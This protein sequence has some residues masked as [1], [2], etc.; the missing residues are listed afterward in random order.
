MTSIVNKRILDVDTVDI[1]GILSDLQ[2]IEDEI[3]DSLRKGERKYLLRMNCKQREAYKN[4]ESMGQVLSVLVWDTI[5]PEQEILLPD[6]LDIV[7]VKIPNAEAIKDM[8]YKYPEEYNRIVT[9]LLN[10]PLEKFR[11]DGIKYIAIPNSLEKIPDFIIPYIDYEYIVSRNLGTFR[12]IRESLQ[13]QDI[14]KDKQTFF[15]NI[16]YNTNIEI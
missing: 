14:G 6:K 16:R 13:I 8:Q 2:K 12:S 4:P 15:S 7:L 11:K 1:P 5:Y 3:Y 9:Y 10:G